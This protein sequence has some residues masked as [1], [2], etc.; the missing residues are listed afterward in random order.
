MVCEISASTQ[1]Q[2]TIPAD[3]PSG[4]YS[5]DIVFTISEDGIVWST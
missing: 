3:L 4:I 2:V 1:L 5:G